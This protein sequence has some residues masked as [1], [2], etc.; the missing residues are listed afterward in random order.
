[1]IRLLGL[2]VVMAGLGLVGCDQAEPTA[3]AAA[4]SKATPAAEESA[5]APPVDPMSRLARKGLYSRM[6]PMV[7]L[8]SW[9]QVVTPG[10]A[11]GPGGA[12]A[13]TDLPPGEGREVTF[14]LCGACHSMK[15]V[16]QQRLP[17][18][19]WDELWTWMIQTQ[20]MPDPGPDLK[21]QIV[22]YLKQNFAS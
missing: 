13:M 17:E 21:K 15:L 11:G 1:M 3:G 6:D 7:T 10:L 4:E 5:A 8:R 16:V 9:E 22:T 12:V 2:I 20:G 19:R 14:A 18:H